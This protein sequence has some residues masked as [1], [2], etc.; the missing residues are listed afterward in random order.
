M[1]TETIPEE[2][3]GATK[4][5][6]E[7]LEKVKKKISAISKI[8]GGGMNEIAKGMSQEEMAKLHVVMAYSIATLFYSSVLVLIHSFTKTN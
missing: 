3:E 4:E 7:A 1:D 8:G 6:E 5:L 2:V